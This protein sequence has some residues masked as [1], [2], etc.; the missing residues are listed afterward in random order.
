[1]PE[2]PRKFYVLLTHRMVPSLPYT[3]SGTDAALFT[4]GTNDGQ[5]R[6][7]SGAQLDFETKRTLRVMVEVT[8]GADSLGDLDSSAIDDRQ[9]VTITLT[10][11]NEAP[12]VT[13]DETPS[14]VENL[15]RAVALYGLV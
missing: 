10:D 6:V 2:F 4:I 15:N 8:D 3:L 14:V 5:L 7:A 11:V 13:G 9:D 12:V 1:M